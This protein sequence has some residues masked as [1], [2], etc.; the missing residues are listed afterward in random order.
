MQY[1]EQI[2]QINKWPKLK[3]GIKNC[4]LLFTIYSLYEGLKKTTFGSKKSNR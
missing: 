4:G 1:E 3:E 2:E